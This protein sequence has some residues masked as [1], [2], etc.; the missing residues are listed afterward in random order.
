MKL[1]RGSRIIYRSH[2]IH[3]V[4]G[5][6]EMDFGG[7]TISFVTLIRE[8]DGSTIRVPVE[9]MKERGIRSLSD[10]E[11]ATDALE[12][13]GR[14]PDHPDQDWKSRQRE[15]IDKMTAG[16]LRGLAEVMRTLHALALIRPLPQKERRLYEEVRVLLVDEIAEALDLSPVAAEDQIDL[17]LTPPGM[18][19]RPPESVPTES[20][21]IEDTHLLEEEAPLALPAVK[22]PAE[23]L[24]TD[25]Q[26]KPPARKATASKKAESK[27]S[28]TKK[29]PTRKKTASR[30]APARKK[31]TS[32][33]TPARKKTASRKAP[34]RKKTASKKT[35]ARKKVSSEK[36]PAR[37]KASSKRAPTGKKTSRKKAPARKK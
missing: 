24:E 35:P 3:R 6:E 34:V 7:E 5:F 13:L 11:E 25:K 30:K 19:T 37:K 33:K 9:R 32:K 12:H 36:T 4:K 20:E 17:A 10:S 2:G 31:T 21:G 23:E 26:K 28:T 16:G 27:K 18:K 29:A 15:H 1:K 8:R 14:L 22:T